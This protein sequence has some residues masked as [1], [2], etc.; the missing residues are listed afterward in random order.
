MGRA[1]L[2]SS[3]TI[4]KL[5]DPQ[6]SPIQGDFFLE[7]GAGKF[8]QIVG[9]VFV[10]GVQ[11]RVAAQV[12]HDL[13]DEIRI[14]KMSASI[15]VMEACTFSSIDVLRLKLLSKISITN[16]SRVVYFSWIW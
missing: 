15:E 1:N 16:K 2:V 9:F 12:L 7:Q 8:D 13:Y 11:N 6:K 4:I 14:W 3:V 10:P 5:L